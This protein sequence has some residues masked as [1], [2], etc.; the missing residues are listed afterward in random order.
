MVAF[1]LQVHRNEEAICVSRLESST[2]LR[3]ACSLSPWVTPCSY[4][5]EIISREMD[6]ESILC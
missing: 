6:S 1:Q 2:D 4:S 5:I 3:T